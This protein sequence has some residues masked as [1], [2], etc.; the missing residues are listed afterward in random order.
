MLAE[1]LFLDLMP[2]PFSD[3]KR[4]N[5][6]NI[7]GAL[8][9]PAGANTTRGAGSVRF[10]QAFARRY[11]SCGMSK[12]EI[13]LDTV[14]GA[15]SS[16]LALDIFSYIN[17]MNV[18]ADVGRAVPG[19]LAAAKLDRDGILKEF[20]SEWKTMIGDAIKSA[21]Q[22]N[23]MQKPEDAQALHEALD[24]VER[25]SVTVDS[26]QIGYAVR[27]MRQRTA[28]V[29][30]EIQKRL[31]IL[32][33]DRILEDPDRG[34]LT[35]L[36]KGGYFELMLAE[37]RA[38]IDPPGA[39]KKGIFDGLL[40]E[41]VSDADKLRALK[42]YQFREL[43]I[44][45]RS[46][47]A[48]LLGAR[49]QLIKLVLA[50]LR[51]AE[52][53]YLFTLAEQ[54]LLKEA[55][56]AARELYNQMNATRNALAMFLQKAEAM[57]G[58]AQARHNT[59]KARLATGSHVLFLQL[60]DLDRDWAQYYKLGL[61][62]VTQ[63]PAEVDA[64]REYEALLREFAVQN[65]LA[66]LAEMVSGRVT[67]EINRKVEE[68]C[69]RRFYEDFIAHPR[70]VNIL[71][72]PLLR[73]RATARQTIQ[74]FVNHA[75][76]MLR[77][78][79]KMAATEVES[80]TFLYLGLADSKSPAAQEFAKSVED[81]TAKMEPK[82]Q[83]NVIDT[84][85]ANEIYLY[86]STY[87][88]PLP[89]VSLVQNE[90]HKAYTDFYA[91]FHP[92][93][94]NGK[95]AVAIPLH[96]S[97]RWEGRFDDLVIYSDRD[98]QL[99]EE[100]LNIVNLA[101]ALRVLSVRTS[102]ETGMPEFF[103]KEAPP[104]VGVRSLNQRRNLISNLMANASLRSLLTDEVRRRESALTPPQLYAFFW[105][106]QAQYLSPTLEQDTP[107]AQLLRRKVQD[108]FARCAALHQAD[109][110]AMPAIDVEAMPAGGQV[111]WIRTQNFGLIWENNNVQP[112]L[113]GVE[114]WRKP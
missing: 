63:Q 103:Y 39:G 69:D 24:K 6:S 3:A 99:L 55:R 26:S 106:L 68:F 105:A 20:G 32:V 18:D 15:C 114:L 50:R 84:G 2:G 16:Q 74:N 113:N 109:P 11:A 108:V 30:A 17:R 64:R 41:S 47:P 48:K 43:N 14:R 100:V 79:G 61:D 66:G 81:L 31:F 75:R 86:S 97:K 65:G 77:H 52:E 44:A 102:A 73:D 101:P 98:A 23:P 90:C 9:G 33:R 13:P 51:D 82:P 22:A 45:L 5:Y 104:F 80:T 67:D 8:S 37:T 40:E 87:A 34:L 70:P 88:F 60:F 28:A 62:Q 85:K 27:W 42:E 89:A 107:D 111:D 21:V 35:A 29:N 59:F 25:D 92:G 110:Q 19:D 96:L 46:L 36:R 54:D 38:L 1:T 4:S 112:V 71:E 7:V 78:D 91:Q 72:H 12:I 57:R 49:E 58:S 95:P 10:T 76:P 94:A 93:A 53:Q 83:I 56:N